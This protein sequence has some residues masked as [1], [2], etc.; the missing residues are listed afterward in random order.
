MRFLL[1]FLAKMVLN[2]AALWVA[3][4]YLT[5]FS[6]APQAF[7]FLDWFKISPL[8]QSLITGGILLAVLNTFIRPILKL[9]SFPFLII[10]FGLFNIV[11]NLALLWLADW[12]LAA[13][14]INGFP[15]YLFGSILI[16]IVNTVL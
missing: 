7:H 6:L 13:L 5:D 8:T 11:I 12:W 9:V 1:K 14:T 10:T 15:A 2:A 4:H 3:T 16:G